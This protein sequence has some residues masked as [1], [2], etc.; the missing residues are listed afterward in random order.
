[1]VCTKYIGG[2]HTTHTS[3]GVLN[4]TTRNNMGGLL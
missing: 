4:T 1:M 3:M 2:F